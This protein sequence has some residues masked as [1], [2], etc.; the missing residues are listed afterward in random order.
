[1]AHF[2]NR[3]MKIFTTILTAFLL[4]TTLNGFSQ[5]AEEIL[6]NKSMAEYNSKN[7]DKAISLMDEFINTYPDF[8]NI[9]MIYLNRASAKSRNKD[10]DGAIKDYTT[11]Y[12]KDTN[13]A[14]AIRQ[15]GYVKKQMGD[16]KSALVDYEFALKINPKLGNAYVNKAYVLKELGQID[17]SCKSYGKA[18]ELGVTSIAGN[19]IQSC[20]SNS[21][22]IQ[23]YTYKILTDKSVDMT[24]GYTEKNPIKA[25]AGPRGQRGYLELLRDAQGNEIEYKRLGSCCSYNSEN[26]P[27]GL[28]LLDRYEIKY[29]NKKGKKDETVLYIS[30]YDYE[31]PKIP[32]G[33]YS[34][35]DFIK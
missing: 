22:A 33:F 16:L 12:I 8:K 11:A 2:K 25:G 35:Q 15:R 26:S 14:E 18:L 7:Y 17:E 23:K 31:Q 30:F 9:H 28:A 27:L 29:K 1:M 6:Y 3:T 19:I 34:K 21:I 13:Y 4:L 5:S 10:Y 32:V 24:Y 20:D